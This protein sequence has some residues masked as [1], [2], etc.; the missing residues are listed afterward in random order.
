MTNTVLSLL[1]LPS[2]R[3]FYEAG[4]WQ[5]DTIYSLARRSAEATPEKTAVRESRRTVTYRELVDAADRLAAALRARG[6]RR[7]MRVAAWLSSR[8]ETAVVVLACSRNGYV[9]CP[10]LHRDHT[11]GEIVALLRRM[12]AAALVAERGYGADA[13]RA[14][15]FGQ[16]ADVE[17]LRLVVPLEPRDGSQAVDGRLFPDLPAADPGEARD[18]PDSVVYLA[19]T[20]GTTGEPKG[21]M[22][23]DNTLLAPVRAL[24]AD[25]SL[26]GDATVYSLSPLSHNLGFGA[27]I[28]AL[29]RGA[30]LVVHDLPRGASLA[31]RLA[32]TGATFLFGVPTHAMDLLAELRLPGTA[33]LHRLR[34]FRISGAAVPPVVAQELI[35]HGI[36][37]QSGYGMTEAGSHHYTR[38]D[39]D[40]D[41]IVGTSGRACAGYEVRIF[42]KEDPDVELPAG[43]VGQVGGRGASL[44]LG[45]FGDQLV[46][47]SSFNAAGW[48][49]TG[50]LGWMD[51][52]GYL[53]IT[54]RKKDLIIRGGHN[55]YPSRIENLA[56]RHGDVA[57]AA[58][59]PVP[60]ERL[61]EKVCLVV[62]A[63]DG[64]D[65]DPQELL[66][67]LDAVGLSK[68]DMPE[69]FA[70]VPA[71]P[72]MP[73]GKVLKRRLQ[74]MVADGTLAPAAVRFRAPA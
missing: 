25:W 21:V 33:A 40:P 47:E 52:Q 46:T 26:D 11:V 24:A 63:A 34:G 27:M 2:A 30:E 36:V 54:G 39:D 70:Q 32:E 44:M 19:F 13:D 65:V 69:Y 51:A 43:E 12:D 60:D 59:I 62:T 4:F 71:M 55:I 15:L 74:E 66:A 49:M 58:V 37:P 72:L 73:S 29:T 23:S 28:L 18:D 48:F 68:Y 17:S 42:S 56:L 8:V 57:Q 20:S 50:D 10:S 14:D 67:H 41:L 45:Y 22:H 35:D 6:L 1:D 53:R 9:C 31:A 7:G 5:A 3:T 64:R 61:G 38:P 16:A